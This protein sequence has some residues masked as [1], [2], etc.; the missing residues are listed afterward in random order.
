MN[1]LSGEIVNIEVSGNISIVSAK[2]C[3]GIAM[4]A[5][6]IET[7]ETAEYLR[8]GNEINLL[9]KETEVIIGVGRDHLISLQ[10]KIPGTVAL[11]DQGK[12]LSRIVV[13]TQGC[14]ITAVISSNAVSQLD[15]QKGSSVT[16]MIKLNEVML[17]EL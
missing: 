3:D 6:V 1:K 5:I 9:F 10:N 14:E 11:I 15:L 7:P 12:L 4:K 17:S 16:A 2:I 8:K 13:N